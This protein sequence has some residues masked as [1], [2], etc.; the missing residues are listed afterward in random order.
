VE[1][2][3]IRERIAAIEGELASVITV[4]Q[5]LRRAIMEAQLRADA[6]EARLGLLKL[7]DVE[8]AIRR[9]SRQLWNRT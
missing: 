1:L 4:C 2:I 3:E 6:E 9:T 8:S 7:E 5:G